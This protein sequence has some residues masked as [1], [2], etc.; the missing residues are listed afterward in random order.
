MR[1]IATS[2]I[3]EGLDFGFNLLVG[4]AADG[5]RDDGVLA[6]RLLSLI[7]N[8][9][10][11]RYAGESEVALDA[12][13]ELVDCVPLKYQRNRDQIEAQMVWLREQLPRGLG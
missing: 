2:S 9:V 13:E 10:H 1:S 3:E 4:P 5:G 6:Q 7:E 12:L 8:F 11:P